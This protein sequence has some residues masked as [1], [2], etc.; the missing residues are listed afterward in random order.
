MQQECF[1]VQSFE[2]QLGNSKL[3]RWLQVYTSAQGGGIKLGGKE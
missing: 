2:F 3:K 1:K